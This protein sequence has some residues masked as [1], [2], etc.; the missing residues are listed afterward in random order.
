MRSSKWISNKIKG[1]PRFN[2]VLK[3]SLSWEG[4]TSPAVSGVGFAGF[5]GRELS[6]ASMRGKAVLL[7]VLVHGLPACGRMSPRAR[8]HPERFRVTWLYVL[9]ANADRGARSVL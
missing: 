1:D 7:Y 8:R 6:L 9:G 5:E 4:K 2:K 3:R